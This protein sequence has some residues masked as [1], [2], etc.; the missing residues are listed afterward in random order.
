VRAREGEGERQKEGV[1]EGE[2]GIS[3]KGGCDRG[4]DGVRAREG[5]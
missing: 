3:T 2:R 5:E 4:R 1:T